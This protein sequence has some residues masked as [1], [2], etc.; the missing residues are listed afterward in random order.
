MEMVCFMERHGQFGSDHSHQLER[1]EKTSNM[2]R[3]VALTAT[4]RRSLQ[5]PFDATFSRRTQGHHVDKHNGVGYARFPGL[6]LS[7][8]VHGFYMILSV[9]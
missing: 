4:K 3:H 7:Q 1:C 6:F 9:A 2:V 5:V 8:R